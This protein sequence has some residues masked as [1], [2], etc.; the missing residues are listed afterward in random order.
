M[1]ESCE[2]TFI[3]SN[4]MQTD[5]WATGGDSL[6]ITD[7]GRRRARRDAGAG[8]GTENQG[9]RGDGDPRAHFETAYYDRWPN[10]HAGNSACP[11]RG[12]WDTHRAQHRTCP[13]YQGA[14]TPL[15]PPLL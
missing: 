6:I 11:R 8:G 12:A 1:Q 15:T 13:H 10:G 2:H 14:M 4:T 3:Q 7:R 5:Y 9:D